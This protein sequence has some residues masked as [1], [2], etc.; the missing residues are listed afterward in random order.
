MNISITG[1]TKAQQDTLL[2]G[3]SDTPPVGTG[4]GYVPTV[5]AEGGLTYAPPAGGDPAKKVA[6][7]F[8]F[9]YD[10]GDDSIYT[11]GQPVFLAKGVPA[12]AFVNAST[13]GSVGKITWAQAEEM[14]NNY[15]A[16]GTGYEI[17]CHENQHDY[18]DPTTGAATV[19]LATSIETGLATFRAHGIMADY[20]AYPGHR[21]NKRGQEL[22]RRYYLGARCGGAPALNDIHTVDLH[23]WGGTGFGDGVK[24]TKAENITK[25]I[26]ALIEKIIVNGSGYYVSCFHSFV[27]GRY[28][29]TTSAATIGTAIDMIQAAGLRIISFSQAN[30]EMASRG[31]LTTN[32]GAIAP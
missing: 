8:V 12:T 20:L 30:H 15:L 14:N 16:N 4:Q 6:P 18:F 17:Q 25:S 3:K 5:N 23:R 13:I 22:A 7:A 26:E 27:P 24:L 28:A 29:A 32:A 1:Y 10:D 2:A 31:Y 9:T 21:I 11:D 19:A